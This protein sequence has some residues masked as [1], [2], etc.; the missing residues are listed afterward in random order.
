LT[1]SR[2]ILQQGELDG[3]CLLYSILNAFKAIYPGK[4]ELDQQKKV[5]SRLIGITPSLQNFASSG[6]LIAAIPN[7]EMDV[8]IKSLLM[9]QYSEILTNWLKDKRHNKSPYTVIKIEP[10]TMDT[11]QWYRAMITEPFPDD[12]AYILCLREADNKGE[13]TLE[14]GPTTEHWVAIV[15]PVGFNLAVACSYTS[16]T[17]GKIYS[18]D[19]VYIGS[20]TRAYNNQIVQKL[21]NSKVFAGSRYKISIS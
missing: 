18:E 17:L 13:K 12:S 1:A 11:G 2:T 8:R 4:F 10:V 5:W 9:N 6:S 15:G 16:H 7:N 3:F 14:H 21:T 20:K 19:E